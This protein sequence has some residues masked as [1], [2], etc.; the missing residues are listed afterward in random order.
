MQILDVF[1]MTDVFE[2]I[3]IKSISLRFHRK[4]TS[5]IICWVVTTDVEKIRHLSTEHGL[6]Y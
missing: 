2:G 3:F 4:K 1:H 6:I 5:K